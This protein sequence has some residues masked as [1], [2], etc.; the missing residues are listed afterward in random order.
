MAVDDPGRRREQRARAGQRRL[1]RRRLARKQRR[2]STPLASARAWMTRS[3]SASSSAGGHDQLAAVPVRDAALAAIGVERVLAGRRR[4]RAIRLPARVI[5]AGVD[6]LAVARGGL[7]A[8]P[9]GRIQHQHL[10]PGQ[11][12]RP[13][14]GKADHPGADDNALH[15]VHSRTLIPWGCRPF[16]LGCA[17]VECRASPDQ[18]RS[19]TMARFRGRCSQEP[20]EFFS[21][22]SPNSL[23]LGKW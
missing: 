16:G 6:H 13:G 11:R 5:D 18:P 20:V 22:G 15:L 19:R 8:D 4:S 12:Q 3:R 17:V 7:G 9:V 21:K 23:A 14:D 1:Q 10:A 2:S